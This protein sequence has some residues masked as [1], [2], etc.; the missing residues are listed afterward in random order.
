MCVCVLCVFVCVF[1]FILFLCLCCNQELYT[2]GIRQSQRSLGK[3]GLLYSINKVLR[4]AAVLE[5]AKVMY[6]PAAPGVV[7]CGVSSIL[8]AP[9]QPHA[10]MPSPRLTSLLFT[11]H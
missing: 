7:P 3:V 6:Q 8:L 11:L 5:E 2:A 4:I 9:S 10:Q 1:L